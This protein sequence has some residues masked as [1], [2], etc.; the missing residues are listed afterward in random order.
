MNCHKC[1]KDNPPKDGKKYRLPRGWKLHRENVWC[2]KCWNTHFVLRAVAIPVVKPL[3]SDWE[4]LRTAVGDAWAYFTQC[5]NWMTDE[6]YARDIRRGS[7]AGKM[8]AMPT[9]YLYPE[10]VKRF[11]ELPSS[12]VA[13][14]EQSV[15]RKYASTRYEIV[16]IRARALS[17][18]RY[19]VP[20]AMPNQ[21][22]RAEFV[23]AG[24]DGD[25]VPCVHVTLLRGQKFTLQ[26][27]GGPEFR[28]QLAAFRQIE[29]G[30]AVKGEIAIYRVRVQ[31]DSGGNGVTGRENGQK[32]KFRLM[33]KMVAWLPR[34]ISGEKSGVLPLRSDVDALLAAFDEKGERIWCLNA[35]HVR[36]WTAEHRRMLQRLGE[37]QKHELRPHAPFHARRAAAADKFSNRIKSFILET[38]AHFAAFAQR[39]KYAS[40]KLD[41]SDHR[42]LPEFQWYQLEE[43]IRTKLDEFG[44]GVEAIASAPVP[45]TSAVALAMEETE[46]A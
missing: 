37:D 2:D 31:S 7:V 39:R 40:V 35:D 44:I 8:P 26:L 20:F 16:W 4:S 15:K 41:L 22:W 17:T 9:I 14:L 11:P 28:R 21:N 27:K 24:K 30:D 42:Y 1:N 38:A 6:L 13:G 12:S 10:A 18:Y 32:V 25:K 5:A 36:R 34:K 33:V 43:R 45:D 29:Q 3:G 19:P 46:N 23:P